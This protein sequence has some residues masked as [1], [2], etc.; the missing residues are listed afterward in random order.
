M[1]K[2][3]QKLTDLIGNTPLLQ[4]NR[5]SAAVNAQANI[6]V[7]IE[8]FNPLNSVKDRIGLA[9]IEAAERDGPLPN[10]FQKTQCCLH[11]SLRIEYFGVRIEVRL[12]MRIMFRMQTIVCLPNTLI[13]MQISKGY[14]QFEYKY[15]KAICSLN[16]NIQRLFA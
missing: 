15:P 6:I 8:A 10:G 5:Y 11:K 13:P 14:L 16:T 2:I 9:M 12:L 7:K 1:T 3:A 4:V